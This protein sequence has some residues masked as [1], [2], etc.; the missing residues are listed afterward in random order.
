MFRIFLVFALVFSGCSTTRYALEPSADP[1][2]DTAAYFQSGLR[3]RVQKSGGVQA[4]LAFDHMNPPKEVTFLLTLANQGE[5]PFVFNPATATCRASH[6]MTKE[7]FINTAVD[8]EA[9][10]AELEKKRADL[11]M[12]GVAVTAEA[13]NVTS[14]LLSALSNN[15]ETYARS[16]EQSR[17]YDR[18]NRDRQRQQSVVDVE[19]D[20]W[21]TRVLRITTLKKGASVSGILVCP[22]PSG[23]KYDHLDVVLHP[24]PADALVFPF[25][26]F[27]IE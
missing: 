13:L 3:Y 21:R 18:Q 24:M 2:L 9:H 27:E 22:V 10:I 6:S 25:R 11:E 8:P 20:Y 19:I 1:K 4:D 12:S 23:Y 16:R 7:V 26:K 17:D 5:A 15:Q 14:G